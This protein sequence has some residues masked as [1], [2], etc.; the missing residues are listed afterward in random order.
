MKLTKQ[1]LK[2]IIKEELSQILNEQD[3][4]PQ[5]GL[6][7]NGSALQKCI[8]NSQCAQ[9]LGPP[10][11]AFQAQLQA[12]LSKL[13]KPIADAVFFSVKQMIFV[14]G[15]Q[16]LVNKTRFNVLAAMIQAGSQNT[17]GPSATTPQTGDSSNEAPPAQGIAKLKAGLKR[18]LDDPNIPQAE[19]EEAKQDF[20]EAIQDLQRK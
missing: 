2:Q 14:G 13:P 9:R 10:F 18:I 4:D 6:P 20:E 11:E 19:K 1:K 15:S 17:G 16:E 5:T 12:T 3:L 8:Q 7:L